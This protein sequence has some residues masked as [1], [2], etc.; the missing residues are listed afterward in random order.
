MTKGIYIRN[1]IVCA[2]FIRFKLFYT[3]KNQSSICT[4]HFTEDPQLRIFW[5]N[6]ENILQKKIERNEN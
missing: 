2:W 6:S 5:S 4:S 1:A 3:C